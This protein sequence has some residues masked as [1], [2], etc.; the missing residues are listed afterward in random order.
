LSPHLPYDDLL[1]RA[2][3]AALQAGRELSSRFGHAVQTRMKGVDD[4]VTEADLAASAV[5]ESALL[6][7]PV[8]EWRCEESRA[9][10]SGPVFWAVDPMD[11]TKSFLRG[12]PDFTVSV[13][14]IEHGEVVLGIVHNPMTGETFLSRRGRGIVVE[15]RTSRPAPCTAASLDLCRLLASRSE[16]RRRE[17]AEIE[18]AVGEVLPCG[19]IAYKLARVAV[20]DAHA[21]LSRTPKS[22]W[23]VAAGALLVEEAGGR[24]TDMLGVPLDGRLEDR[25]GVVAA[26]GPLHGELL[27]FLGERGL[28][29]TT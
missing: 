14:L 18:A 26:A 21:T 25:R 23:D 20:G 2:R 22:L 12:D 17:L 9:M 24:A 6:R 7:P 19:S 8:S 5:L 15:G 28:D 29:R 4:P 27:R 13:A 16:L 10:P 3:A 11:G 1:A